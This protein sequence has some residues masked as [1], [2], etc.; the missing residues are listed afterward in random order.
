MIFLRKFEAPVPGTILRGC[1]GLGC[2][3]GVVE[4]NRGCFPFD[5]LVSFLRCA[6]RRCRRCRR[7]RFFLLRGTCT[8]AG[9]RCRSEPAFG[10][11]CIGPPCF[12]SERD[13]CR[14]RRGVLH[15]PSNGQPSPQSGWDPSSADQTQNSSQQNSQGWLFRRHRNRCYPDCSI[16]AGSFLV[17]AVAVVAVAA[18]VVVVAVVV[19]SESWRGAGFDT[20]SS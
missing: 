8:L 11:C 13:R 15:T 10:S 2:N 7:C 3:A 16:A 20:R 9:T 4:K 5:R 14:N 17:A 18:V 19:A 1:S 12:L 6:C